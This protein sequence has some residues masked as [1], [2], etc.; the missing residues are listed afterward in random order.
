MCKD[1]RFKTGFS[2]TPPKGLVSSVVVVGE[3]G[4]GVESG[5]E[6][7]FLSFRTA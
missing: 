6:G 5:V 7:K 2:L 3:K 4:G 1:I